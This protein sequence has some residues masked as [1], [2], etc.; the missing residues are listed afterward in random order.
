VHGGRDSSP[1]L[2]MTLDP[3]PSVFKA[4]TRESVSDT[5]QIGLVRSTSPLGV[6]YE[7]VRSASFNRG[8]A[9]LPEAH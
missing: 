2:R 6:E 4:M 9:R 3:Q 1:K 5:I 7:S 8:H